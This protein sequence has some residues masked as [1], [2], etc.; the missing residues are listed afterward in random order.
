MLGLPVVR[1]LGVGGEGDQALSH[2]EEPYVVPGIP[3]DNGVESRQVL[4][5]QTS[6]LPGVVQVRQAQGPVGAGRYRQVL[7]R[8]TESYHA[9]VIYSAPCPQR[10]FY[11]LPADLTR[12]KNAPKI[13]PGRSNVTQPISTTAAR[14]LPERR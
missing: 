8:I 5:D 6:H 9:Q 2:P 7:R 3:P 4:P 13:P 1:E 11:Y 14:P 10:V 12:M